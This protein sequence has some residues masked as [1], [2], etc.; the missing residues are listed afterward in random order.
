MDS[1]IPRRDGTHLVCELPAGTEIKAVPGSNGCFVAV[2]PDHPLRIIY[3]S[4]HSEVLEPGEGVPVMV[5]PWRPFLID[6]SR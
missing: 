4:G 5:D 1:P 3:P 6:L 2:H